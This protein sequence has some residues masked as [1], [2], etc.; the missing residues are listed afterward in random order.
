[1]KPLLS[2]IIPTRNRMIYA[3]SAIQS[4]LKIEDKRIEL[5]VQDNSTNNEL[6]IYIE[7]NINDNRLIYH[8]D[9]REMSTVHNFNK[10]MDFVHGE[11]ICFIGDDDGVNAEIIDATAWAKHNQLDALIG[12]GRIG[13]QWPND[14]YSGKLI[15][16]PYSGKTRRVN[17]EE[18]L[19]RFLQ[20]GGVY[21]L[22]YDLPKVYHGILK[23]ECFDKVKDKLG[24]YFGGLSV[25]IFSSVALSLVAQNVV[26][27]DYPLTIAGSSAASEQTHRTEESKRLDL[28]DAPHFRARGAYTWSEKVP[29]VYSGPTIWAESG[30]KALEEFG[31]FDL[32][33]RI[34][35]FSLAASISFFSPIHEQTI[36]REYLNEDK[37]Y[38][39]KLKYKYTKLLFHFIDIRHRA[40]SRIHR[41]RIG[42][43]AVTYSN[44][45][46][47]E[48]AVSTFQEHLMK[49]ATDINQY[50]KV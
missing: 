44:L 4:I 46:T 42:R 15:I 16:Y 47:I 21:Y 35:E 31:R 26:A 2:I 19:D 45:N 39:I 20:S 13:Y 50:L 1:M 8:Y 23:R 48:D 37:S 22:K 28:K 5:I 7:E 25:D 49:T 10:S 34:D 36:L 9:S 14:R 30:I 38:L 27:I 33:E 6:E 29:A 17:M 40:V 24:Y 43:S 32:I 12:S 11:Y 41:I 3:I 18:E